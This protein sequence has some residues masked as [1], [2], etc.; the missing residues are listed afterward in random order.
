MNKEDEIIDLLKKVLEKQDSFDRR[1]SSIEQKQDIF[2]QRIDSFEQKMDLFEE[3]QNFLTTMVQ[4]LEH[5]QEHIQDDQ[6]GDR[7]ILM[8]LWQSR[9]SV[10]AK[11]KWDFIWKTTAFNAVLLTIMYSLLHLS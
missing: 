6:R 7:K 9:E 2:E 3:K 11:V 4:R 10:V 5:G 1:L 8:D